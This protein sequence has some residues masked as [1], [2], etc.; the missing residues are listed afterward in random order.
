MDYALIEDGVVV[1]LIYLHPMNIDEFPNAKPTNGLPV[2]MGDIFVDDKFYHNGK[3][4]TVSNALTEED[5]QRIKDEAI[6]E[7]Q[8]G[9]SD[10]TL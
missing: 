6:A 3:E 8:K 1:N 2:Q 10:G 5:V 4:V 9:V 7:V